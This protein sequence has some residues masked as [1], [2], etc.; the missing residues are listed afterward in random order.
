MTASD[1]VSARDAA[2]IA[3]LI[4]GAS[5]RRAAELA[6]TSESTITRRMREP[7]F[8]LAL[9][10]A[11]ERALDEAVAQLGALAL[12]AVDVLGRAMQPGVQAELQV[13]AALAVAGMALKLRDGRLVE[14]ERRLDEVERR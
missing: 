13:R 8:L 5:Q 12:L 14:I 10:E 4:G 6:G 2:I 3:A 9:A 1:G 7:D 11:R